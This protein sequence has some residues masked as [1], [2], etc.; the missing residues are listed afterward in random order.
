MEKAKPTT[1]EPKASSTW[2]QLEGH[3]QLNAGST[4]ISSPGG[5]EVSHTRSFFGR[6]G[7]QGP[8][9]AKNLTFSGSILS[10]VSLS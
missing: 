10:T 4:E 5:R 9:Q 3:C 8:M 7:M 6:S 1:P 2:E